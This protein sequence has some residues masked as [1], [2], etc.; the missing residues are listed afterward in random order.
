MDISKA[1]PAP[2][3]VHDGG[4]GGQV[5]CAVRS[6]GM[7]QPIF[8]RIRLDSDTTDSINVILGRNALDVMMR[9]LWWPA[10]FPFGWQVHWNKDDFNGKGADELLN[11][12]M[13]QKF[14]HPFIALIEADKWYKE[15]VEERGPA[16]S[17]T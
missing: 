11:W 16:H 12:S 3:G 8:K 5:I 14:T 15:N 7:C 2:W 17:E 6:D 1:S 10:H 4:G 13:Q 9:R